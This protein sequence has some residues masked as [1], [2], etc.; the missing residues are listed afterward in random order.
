VRA[1]PHQSQIFGV[2]FAV[3]QH[4][5]GADVA[6]PMIRPLPLQGMIEKPMRQRLIGRQQI[7]GIRKKL[8]DLPSEL[9]GFSRR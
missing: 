2:G 3:N 9:A 5:I 1:K 8:V 7:D 4:E 6:V